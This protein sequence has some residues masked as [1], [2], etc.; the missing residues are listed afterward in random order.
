MKPKVPSVEEYLRKTTFDRSWTGGRVCSTCAHKRAA[1]I[2]RELRVFAKAKKDGLAMPWKR[3]QRDR[4]VPVYG[5]RVVAT[6]LMRHVHE[7][8]GID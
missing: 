4:L 5:L 7:C 3:F 8:L 6:S 1:D 2:N